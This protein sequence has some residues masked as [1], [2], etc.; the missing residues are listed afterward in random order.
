MNSETSL[1]FVSDLPA[2]TP[3]PLMEALSRRHLC[4]K[5]TT[6]AFAALRGS[7]AL[8]WIGLVIDTD[9]T[10]AQSVE[11]LKRGLLN[12]D[13]DR[14][15]VVVIA[16]PYGSID[17][18]FALIANSDRVIPR[19]VIDETAAFQS[20]QLRS[21][22]EVAR[23]D[24]VRNGLDAI[25]WLILKYSQP[26]TLSAAL[27]A[28]ESA[29]DKVFQLAKTGTPI[30]R[31]DMQAH[32]SMVLA[33]VDEH[34]LQNWL[35]AV[36]EHHSA[37]YRH[38]LAVTG[39]AAAFGRSLGF[40]KH[41]IGRLTL[42]ALLHDIGKAKVPV[43]ILEKREPLTPREEAILRKH[44]MDGRRMVE[45]QASIDEDL[46]DVISQH[47]EYLD[48]SGYPNG[49]SGCE[50]GDLTRLMMISDRFANLI[51]RQS[52][53]NSVSSHQAFEILCG[54]GPKLDVPLVK[55]FKGVIE[56]LESAV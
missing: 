24:F 30:N 10:D 45:T 27:T 28:G 15:F 53:Q 41:D 26:K 17:I 38:S 18:K 13:R 37:T 52:Y 1:L 23:A 50:I 54:M 22:I 20:P 29:L 46:L 7:A 56:Q 49:L 43:E 42:S 11:S 40:T 2:E 25:E 12:L 47:H 48:G 33:G 36:R 6:R 55:A 44:P 21:V 5:L 16:D 19:I 34:G 4:T 35:D 14:T 8:A 3:F 39:I 31:A 51:S 9:L 32:N